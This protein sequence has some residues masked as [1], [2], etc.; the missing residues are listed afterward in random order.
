LTARIYAR[1]SHFDRACTWILM[2]RQVRAKG[3]NIV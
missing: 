2:L 1:Y 3:G